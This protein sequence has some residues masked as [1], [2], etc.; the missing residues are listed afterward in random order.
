LT[1]HADYIDGYSEWYFATQLDLDDAIDHTQNPGLQLLR[2]KR[3]G[4]RNHSEK[5]LTRALERWHQATNNMS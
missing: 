4:G 1:H 2:S 3:D 5:S